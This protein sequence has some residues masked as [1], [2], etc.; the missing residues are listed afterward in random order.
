[1]NNH[2][3]QRA[4]FDKADKILIKVIKIHK[5]GKRIRKEL[6]KWQGK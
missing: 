3:F 2:L 6:R 5:K 4:D 1:M